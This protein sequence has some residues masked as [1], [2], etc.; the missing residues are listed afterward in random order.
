[1]IAARCFLLG[2]AFSTTVAAQPALD[3]WRAIEHDNVA[4]AEKLI[5]AGLPLDREISDGDTPLMRAAF[6][7][8]GKIVA[9]LLAHGASP[10]AANRLGKT[11]LM[12]ACAAS[13]SE[14]VLQ[15]LL[16]AGAQP[17]AKGW[18]GETAYLYAARYKKPDV[19]IL[20]EKSGADP[21]AKDGGGQGALFWAA[22]QSNE[23]VV[24]YLLS[25]GFNVNDAADDAF[26]PLLAAKHDNIR[27]LLLDAGADASVRSSDGE[28][29]LTRALSGP[30]YMEDVELLNRLIAR[31]ADVHAADS[32]GN[33]ALM[34]AAWFGG[35]SE[36]FVRALL[37]H[38][39]EVNGVDRYGKTALMRASKPEIADLLR[40]HG[41]KE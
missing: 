4:D 17:N 22:Y 19:L 18:N 8:R 33:T 23:A 41:A 38:G 28:T 16:R 29:V 24:R 40:R 37:A 25:K 10:N 14:E 36:K 31:G 11:P 5:A 15:I 7:N 26:T 32:T 3:M 6:K 27:R 2:I 21:K 9:M 20:L 1:M 39:A 34:Y 30:G 35:G 13:A 12:S